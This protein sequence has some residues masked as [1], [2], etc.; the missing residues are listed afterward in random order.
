MCGLLH[1]PELD[2]DLEQDDSLELEDLAVRILR[3][4][5]GHELTGSEIMATLFFA[6]DA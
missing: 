6:H 5:I 4:H 1:L 3:L 2:E